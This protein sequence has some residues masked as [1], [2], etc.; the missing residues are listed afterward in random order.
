MLCRLEITDV[1]THFY[2]CVLKHNP[3][4]LLEVV[5]LCLNR[6]SHGCAPCRLRV[7]QTVCP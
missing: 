7:V 1:L 3:D 4:V 6:V 5:Y 2:L